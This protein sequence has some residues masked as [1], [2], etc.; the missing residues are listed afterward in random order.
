MGRDEAGG[1]SI[2]ELLRCIEVLWA[3]GDLPIGVCLV[4][5]CNHSYNDE[6]CEESRI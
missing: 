3:V 5:V 1:G 2:V 6:C 4:I